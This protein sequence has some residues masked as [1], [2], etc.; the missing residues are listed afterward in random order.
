LHG[1]LISL[2]F[3][4]QSLCSKIFYRKQW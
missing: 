2:I 4:T 1:K 3:F